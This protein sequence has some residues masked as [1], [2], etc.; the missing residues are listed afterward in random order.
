MVLLEKENFK[1]Y[2]DIRRLER[3]MSG[4]E[5]DHAAIESRIRR[6]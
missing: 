2:Y 4:L 1:N 6:D 3:R 5:E